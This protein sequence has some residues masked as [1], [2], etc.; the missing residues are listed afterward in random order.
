MRRS[1]YIHVAIC[2]LLGRGDYRYI[3]MIGR[4]RPNTEVAVSH[5]QVE[6]GRELGYYSVRLLFLLLRRHSNL[7]YTCV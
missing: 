5:D 7:I 2:C 6:G 3:V 4:A 1:T